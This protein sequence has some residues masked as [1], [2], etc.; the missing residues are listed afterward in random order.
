[1]LTHSKIETFIHSLVDSLYTV[2]GSHSN[3][4]KAAVKPQWWRVKPQ[5]AAVMEREAAVGATFKCKG[6]TVMVNAL[7]IWK[8]KS[9]IRTLYLYEFRDIYSLGHNH[10]E[11]L[12]WW[13][14]LDGLSIMGR[15]NHD[16]DHSIRSHLLDD[17]YLCHDYS[18][19][20]VW[21]E[22]S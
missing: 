10:S 19:D 6:A 2:K 13:S 22:G 12:S 20:M 7:A 18:L 11:P 3:E 5:K 21:G 9:Q 4:E 1:M 8:I 15:S 14:P 16:C 17:H